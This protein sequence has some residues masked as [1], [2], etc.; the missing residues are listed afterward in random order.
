MYFLGVMFIALGGWLIDSG[1]ESRHPILTLEAIIQEGPNNWQAI[2]GDQSLSLGAIKPWSSGAG[3]AVGSAASAPFAGEVKGIQKVG[4]SPLAP[5]LGLFGLGASQASQS[6]TNNFVSGGTSAVQ[7][8]FEGNA[9][10][11]PWNW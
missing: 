6:Y 2:K 1:V 10:W 7:H 8:M 4:H 9:S 11:E 3:K 5:L